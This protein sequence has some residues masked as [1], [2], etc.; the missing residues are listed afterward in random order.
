MAIGETTKKLLILILWLVGT[1]Q[2]YAQQI[3]LRQA[4]QSGMENYET[5]RSKTLQAEAGKAS[6]IHAKTSLLP[7]LKFSVQQVYGTANAWHGPQY[8]FG[9]GMTTTSMPQSEQNWEAAFGAL[10]MAGFNWTLY[11][12]GQT[13]NNI[14]LAESEY[15]LRQSELEQEKFKHQIRVSAAYFNLL[16]V[17][18]LVKIQEKNIDR[19]K[20]LFSVTQALTSNNIRSEAEAAMAEAEVA[21]SRIALL[22]ARDKVY[23]LSKD[24][25]LVT[26]IEDEEFLLDSSYMYRFPVDR[27]YA[28]EIFDNHPS[29]RRA[30]N[31]VEASNY[32]M[33]VF[34]SE[35]LPRVNLVGAISGKG[36]GFGYNYI[37]VPDAVSHSYIQGVGINRS[38]FLIGIGLNW[39]FTSLFRNRSKIASQKLLS[40]SLETERNLLSRELKEQTHYADKK[41]QLA[42]SQYNE[43]V[44]RRKAAQTSYN[45]YLTMYRNGL[46]SI[47]D[48]AQAMYALTAAESEQEIMAINIWQAYLLK[49]ANNGDIEAFIAQINNI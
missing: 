36:S 7:D 1:N 40:Y 42:Y 23:E 4:L 31:A 35:A 41:L 9:E 15:E 19:A 38:N 43:A 16:A 17:Q 39:N 3:T 14:R 47:S 30:Q 32:K 45:Q 48:L 13:K 44:T 2:M 29:L 49:I 25:A 34:R 21:T 20:T 27:T 18:Q 22:K 28:E 26:G 8:G 24:F 37:Q 33:K 11:S 46:T 10:Y 6:V 12:F 5:I